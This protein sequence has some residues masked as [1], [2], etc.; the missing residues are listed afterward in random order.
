MESSSSNSKERE[1]QQMQMEEREPHQKCLAW[2][3]K[4]K[5][6]L[7]FLHNIN[8]PSVGR[9]GPYEIAFQIFFHEV[10]ETF[11]MKMYHNLNQL[12]WQ[13]ERD[14]LHLSNPK[15]CLDILRTPLVTEDTTLEANLS[16]NSSALDV[17]SVIEGAAKEVCLVTE[18]AT[19]EASLVNED[20]NSVAMESTDDFVTSLEQLN[21]SSSSWN[22]VDAE[23]N[24]L[25]E[26]NH[27]M[28][29]NVF[30]YGTQNHEQPEYI[31]D[32]YVVNKNN[33]DIKSDIPNMDPNRDKEEH[34]Y[35]DH[36]QQRA[37]FASLINNLK[38]VA[39][40][41]FEKQTFSKLELNQDDLFKISF[42]QSINERVRNRLSEEFE[43]LVKDVNLQ[44]NCFEKSLVK[45]MKDDLKYVMSLEDEFDETCLILDIQQ[46]FWKPQ[47][48]LVKSESYSHVYENET[49]EQNSSLENENRW[50]KKILFRNETS[51]FETK[52][53]ELE[54]IL[55]QQTK[56]FKDAKVDFSKK[57]DKFETYF[58]KLE[59]TKV[60]KG[61][62]PVLDFQKP[63]AGVS[64]KIYTGESSKSFSKRVS[65]FT[66]YSL[67][68]YRK[69][70][71]KP[72]VYETPTPQKVFNLVDSSKKRKISETPN[73]C[74]TPA[75]QV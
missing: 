51:R 75:K 48:D 60:D 14:N 16:T 26:V 1:L 27:D 45:E 31:P 52:I 9:N 56:D 40:L 44:L 36:E 68:E 55:A 41:K 22:D 65:Q 64:S 74:F 33:S 2:F 28:F 10:H 5:T 15:S 19:L 21:E 32:T 61:K 3:T 58:E 20:D 46:E 6:H 24:T 25:S 4:L 43:P 7:E 23:K 11:R 38:C 66:T 62:S 49:F 72:Q 37:F 70:S 12:Q 57:I 29:E 34:D 50:E 30:G 67:Q 17:S 53:K 71:K 18:G 47:F 69:F 35:T 54:M 59:N 63:K 13:L 8:S 73:S 39:M 42:E